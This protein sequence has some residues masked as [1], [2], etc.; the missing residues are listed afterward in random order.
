ME[1]EGE[2]EG[3]R[4]AASNSAPPGQLYVILL[5]MWLCAVAASVRTR[6]TTRAFV[7]HLSV[8]VSASR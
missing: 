8:Y 4:T 7:V 6:E 2:G 1:G 3:G 5:K